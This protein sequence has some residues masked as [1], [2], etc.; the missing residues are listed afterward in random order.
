LSDE[1]V[2]AAITE[3]ME[4]NA[5]PKPVVGKNKLNPE[6]CYDGSLSNSGTESASTSYWTTGYIACGIGDVIRFIGLDGNVKTLSYLFLF[7]EKKNFVEK[8][9]DPSGAYTIATDGTAYI[10]YLIPKTG[11]YGISYDNRANCML[12]IND[13]STAYEQYTVTMEGGIAQY[14]DL[15]AIAAKID[16]TDYLKKENAVQLYQPKGDYVLSSK[17]LTLI[18]V[19]AN[20]VSHSWTVYGEAVSN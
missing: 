8:V 7:D 14:I 6:E 17:T 19:D 10:R 13:S 9:T 18:G 12:T 5:D 2:A 4:E 16:L 3:W 11:T 1:Q 20:G 15:D